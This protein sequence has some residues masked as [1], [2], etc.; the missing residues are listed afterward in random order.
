MREQHDTM[1]Q[2]GDMHQGGTGGMHGHM[3]QA[4]ATRL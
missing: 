3:G 1:H 4:P 2:G